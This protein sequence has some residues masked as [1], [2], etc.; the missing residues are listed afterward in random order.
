M[1]ESEQPI[2][3][4]AEDIAEANRLSLS[5]PICASAVE[6][7]V[8][9]PALAPVVCSNCHTLYHRTCW[10]QNGGQCATLGCEHKECYTYGTEIGPLLKIGYSDLPR[11][12]PRT[13]SPNGRSHRLKEEEKR[14][15]REEN[16]RQFWNSLLNRIKRAIG[17]R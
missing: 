15:Q 12:V 4:S 8:G 1:S 9:D 17:W 6:R 14:R 7:N 10:Q 3:I 2:K 5:C 13:P 11:H 16:R